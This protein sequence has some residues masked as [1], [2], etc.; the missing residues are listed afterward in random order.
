MPNYALATDDYSDEY[1]SK[2]WNTSSAHLV[3]NALDLTYVWESVTYA[4]KGS[5]WTATTFAPQMAKVS[6]FSFK[7]PEW[8]QQALE[9]INDL[10]RL[11]PN[12]D[13][14]GAKPI[15]IQSALASLKILASAGLD[16]DALA[17]QL[18]PT[19]RGG[20]QLEWHGA[21]SDLELCVE[22]P[23]ITVFYENTRDPTKNIHHIVSEPAAIEEVRALAKDFN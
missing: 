21:H 19:P 18:V 13:S 20:V 23:M 12:W 4:A 8:L 17:P 22:L 5:H 9:K 6:M 1:T 16:D 15:N 2:S 14:Y 3:Q 11:P 10:L 7:V